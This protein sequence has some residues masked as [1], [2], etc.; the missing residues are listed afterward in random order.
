MNHPFDQLVD[1][2]MQRAKLSVPRTSGRLVRIAGMTIEAIGVLAP[3]GATCQIDG[4]QAGETIE[5]EVVGFNNDILYLMPYGTTDGIAPG[6]QSDSGQPPRQRPYW[7]GAAGSG[8]RRA[9]RAD[10]RT[11]THSL[12]RYL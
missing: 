4:A 7:R 6:C 10:R 1:E 2:K 5:A 11:G 8:C 3:V 12:H 9:G